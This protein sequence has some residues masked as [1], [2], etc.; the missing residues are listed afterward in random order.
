MCGHSFAPQARKDRVPGDPGFCTPGT[1]RPRTRGPRLF[2][3]GDG[4]MARVEFRFLV[5]TISKNAMANDP[6]GGS[7]VQ[8]PPTK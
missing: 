1:Q 6:T 4:G 5:S 7:V 2:R 8:E 3:P